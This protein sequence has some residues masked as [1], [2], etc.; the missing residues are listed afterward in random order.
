[1]DKNSLELFIKNYSSN[2]FDKIK[3][4]WN[5]MH[6]D[7]LK[8]NNL[9]FRIELVDFIVPKI[10]EVNIELVRDLYIELSKF[11]KEA[12]GAPKHFNILGQELLIRDYKKYLMDYLEGASQSMDTYLDSGRIK[13]SKKLAQE[14][15]DYID[16]ILKGELDDKT[17]KLLK[18]FGIERFSWLSQKGN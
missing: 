15:A 2:D 17:Q 13:I 11:A 4:D 10:S 8:D 1:M 12:W 6:A 5:E 16:E 3:F 14:I 18:L 7:Q 9:E